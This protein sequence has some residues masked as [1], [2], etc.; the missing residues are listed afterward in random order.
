MMCVQKRVPSTETDSKSP[1]SSETSVIIYQTTLLDILSDLYLHFHSCEN[2]KSRW[3][4]P[5]LLYYMY[6]SRVKD[7]RSEPNQ[8]V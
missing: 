2:L 6:L 1:H 4:F 5:D 3:K 7:D 8:I